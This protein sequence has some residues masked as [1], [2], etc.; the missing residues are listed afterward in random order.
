V[1][2][3]A[4]VLVAL[5]IFL[6]IY[7]YVA[8]P[9][10]LWLFARGIKTSLA[11]SAVDTPFVSIVV[12]A[13]NEEGQIAGAI[14]ALLAQDY[15]A[16]RIQILILSDASTDRTDEIVAS[17]ASR[18]V[19]LMRMTER[20]GKTKAE[21]A[22]VDRLLGTI[23][24]NTDASI[25]LHTA[26]V[27]ELVAHMADP[28]VGVAS[29]RDISVSAMPRAGNVT[30][31][32]YV[33]YEM[34]VRSLES[35]TGGIVGASGSCYAIRTDLHKIQIPEDLS[36]D[37]CAA[38]TARLHGFRA[39][40][41]DEAIC[42]VPS[43]PSLEREYRR[44]VRTISRGMDTLRYRKEVLDPTRDAKFAWKLFSH[45]LCR[46]ALPVS[47][48]PGMAGLAILSRMHTW[49]TT[50]L[51]AGG[52]IALLAFVGVIW[53][54]NRPMPRVIS[55]AAFGVAANLAV[56]NALWRVIHGHKDHVW[57]PT[58]RSA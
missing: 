2:R 37:F 4:E 17:Y 20:S 26:A 50:V 34:W 56:M 24:V 43:T 45:K 38:L 52:A 18:G 31:A 35:R 23:V 15:P 16:P 33:N 48:I 46:W 44:K 9:F 10:I 40:S 12:P 5:P 22:A 11:K 49:A 58:R 6:A 39:V 41:V 14:D 13:Y 3:V 1:I 28:N 32:G 30:E 47:V 57:E 42:L 19:E 51:I 27:R 21:N 7:A 53:P 25:R 29:G 55:L 36:R 8:Y 54:S